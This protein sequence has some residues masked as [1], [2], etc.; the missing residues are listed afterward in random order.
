MMAVMSHSLDYAPILLKDLT[1]KKNI[2][3]IFLQ[4]I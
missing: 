3:Y 1:I 2:H 4:K